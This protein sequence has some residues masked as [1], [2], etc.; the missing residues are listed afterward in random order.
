MFETIL[1]FNGDSYPF[2]FPDD[3]ADTKLETLVN[4]IDYDNFS[5]QRDK[6]QALKN[7]RSQY[8]IRL[9]HVYRETLALHLVYEFIPTSLSVYLWN[10][11]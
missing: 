10:W 9:L 11:L 3:T 8:I 5:H 4:C 7:M 6:F 1:Q 2:D